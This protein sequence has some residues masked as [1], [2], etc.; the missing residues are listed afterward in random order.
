[1]TPHQSI[2]RQ[3]KAARRVS[4][5]LV[6]ITTP[7]P[8]AT[9]AAL[10]ETATGRDAPKIV[11]DVVQGMKARNDAG[12]TAIADMSGDGTG[13]DPTIGNPVALLKLA[14]DKLPKGALLFMHMAH[15]WLA[16]DPM[17]VQAAWNLRDEF[18]SNRRM[19]IMLAPAIELPAELAG[20]VIVFDE[21][22]PG[23]D[24]LRQIIAISM[25]PAKSSRIRTCFPKR[26]KRCRACPRSRRSRS[27]RCPSRKRLDL[28]ECWERKRRQI[29]QTPGLKVH[30]EPVRLQRHRRRDDR[31]RIPVADSLWE[32]R[33]NAIVFI[34]EIEKFMAGAT[35]GGADTSGVSQDQLGTLLA[36]MQ[37]N[38]A[39]GMHLRGAAGLGKEH[40]R[41]GRGERSRRR[42]DPDDP[43][44][45]WRDEGLAGGAERAEPPRRVESDH[46]GE[47][48]GKSLWIATCNAHFRSAAGAA[49]AVHARHV[50]L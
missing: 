30:R 35:G 21:P 29:E 26:S 18:K 1:V 19:L 41:Q 49:P 32:C 45:S 28:S 31:E 46:V 27:W 5:P 13:D 36:Y 34:D 50:L 33:P 47:S 14:R 42:G 15:R 9:I 8:A 17:L 12:K 10:C 44:R 11:W 23:E 6:A 24:E 37:D 22:L 20:D 43:A 40:G 39:A 7:D 25:T 16:V 3:F 4:V 2:L 38:A 48:N